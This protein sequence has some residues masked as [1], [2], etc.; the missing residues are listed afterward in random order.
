MNNKKNYWKGIMVGF[1]IG[2]IVWCALWVFVIDKI[3]RVHK[4]EIDYVI[5][6]HHTK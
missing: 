5:E 6:K 2:T 1:A 4:Q 3:D